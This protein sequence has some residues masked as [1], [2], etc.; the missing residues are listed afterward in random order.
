V[1]DEPGHGP[2]LGLSSAASSSE[3][4]ERDPNLAASL[5]AEAYAVLEYIKDLGFEALIPPPTQGASPAKGSAGAR[6][7]QNRAAPGRGPQSFGG[8]PGQAKSSG[9]SDARSGSSYGGPA[10]GAGSDA[11]GQGTKAG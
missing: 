6:A 9:A 8:Y 5:A 1:T 10:Y 3:P 11:R 7:D 2:S 4:L